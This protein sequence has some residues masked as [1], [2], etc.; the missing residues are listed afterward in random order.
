MQIDDVRVLNL[1][2]LKRGLLCCHQHWKEKDRAASSLQKLFVKVTN[3][4]GVLKKHFGVSLI[5]TGRPVSWWDLNQENQSQKRRKWWWW[6]ERVTTA[7]LTAVVAFWAC[8]C[9]AAPLGQLFKPVDICF[10]LTPP[11]IPLV[12]FFRAGIPSPH[13]RSVSALPGFP[14]FGGWMNGW[15]YGWMDSWQFSA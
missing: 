1:P 10:F 7:M 11:E 13:L 4:W 6:E 15:I 3:L 12:N 8:F 2:W 9:F 5:L 14:Y